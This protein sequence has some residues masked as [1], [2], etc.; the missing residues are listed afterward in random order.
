[1]PTRK[2]E[3][4]IHIEEQNRHR[5]EIVTEAN[6]A[7][8]GMFMAMGW[9]KD[10]YG[11]L[12]LTIADV[13]GSAVEDEKFSLD[14]IDLT[15]KIGTEEAELELACTRGTFHLSQIGVQGY[16]DAAELGVNIPAGLGLLKKVWND[17]EINTAQNHIVFRYTRHTPFRNGH[18]NEMTPWYEGLPGYPDEEDTPE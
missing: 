14:D 18:N 1:M 13:I 17:V 10:E 3:Q 11:T 2:M 8:G 4:P 5:A 9:E 6:A 16:Y 7:L 15:P 12:A